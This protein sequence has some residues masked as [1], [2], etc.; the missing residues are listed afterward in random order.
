VSYRKKPELV[1]AHQWSGS[2]WH[3]MLDFAGRQHVAT[4][5]TNLFLNG[6]VVDKDGW[7]V[8]SGTM[9][10]AMTDKAFRLTYEEVKDT[11]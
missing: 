11:V 7:V 1:E 6:S 10:Y 4:D 9:L 2:N 5:G 3:Q 8:R